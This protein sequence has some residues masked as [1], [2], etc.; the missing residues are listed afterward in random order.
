M[1]GQ[2]RTNKW[3]ALLLAAALAAGS[4]PVSAED[5]SESIA[6]DE[7]AENLVGLSDDGLLEEP[8]LYDETAPSGDAGY[9]EELPNDGEEL[10]PANDGELLEEGPLGDGSEIQENVPVTDEEILSETDG[11]SVEYAG[12]DAA[13][14]AAGTEAE[15][16]PE[17]EPSENASEENPSAAGSAAG[18]ASRRR[19]RRGA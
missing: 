12:T 15:E 10:L 11:G 6:S 19:R 13:D 1:T 4:A 18:A 7:G 2:K 17:T 8:G 14:A 5:L 16:I 9:A 3:L